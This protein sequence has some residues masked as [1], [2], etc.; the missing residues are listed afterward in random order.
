VIVKDY[1]YLRQGN[2]TNSKAGSQFDVDYVL[3]DS[4]LSRGNRQRKEESQRCMYTILGKP[5]VENAL[6]GYNTTV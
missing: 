1:N 4:F 6:D 2:T 3:D 5:C